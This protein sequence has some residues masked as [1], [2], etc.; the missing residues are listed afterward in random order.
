MTIEK[1]SELTG[2]SIKSL[3][4]LYRVSRFMGWLYWGFLAGFVV[5]MAGAYFCWQLDYWGV[6]LLLAGLASLA[7]ALTLF[8][9][10][11]AIAVPVPDPPT[12]FGSAAPATT[13]AL[14]TANLVGPQFGEGIRLGF[15]FKSGPDGNKTS[16]VMRYTGP[17]NL[18]LVAPPRSGKFRDELCA[19]MLEYGAASPGASLVVVD[20]K[21]E[22]CAVTRRQR[23]KLGRVF[24]LSPFH[25][26]LEKD[27]VHLGQPAR[28]S[29]MTALMGMS[30][31]VP[32]CDNL[33]ESIVRDDPRNTFFTASARELLS[34][35]ILHLLQS[36]DFPADKKT[37]AFV[38]H[39]ITTDPFMFARQAFATG[40]DYVKQRVASLA[41]PEAPLDK[42]ANSVL[43]T[44][45][46]ETAFIGNAPI[47]AS[48]SGS[49]FDFTELKKT[50]TTVYVV[51]PARY[52]GDVGGRWFRLI[53]A[54]ALNALMSGGRGL[55]VLVVIDE[56]SALGKMESIQRAMAYSSG[57]GFQVWPIMQSLEQFKIDYKGWKSFLGTA[58]VQQFYRPNEME[59][60]TYISELTGKKT[61]SVP[62]S[63]TSTN[64]AADGRSTTSASNSISLQQ[65]PLYRPDQIMMIGREFFIMRDE[66]VDYIIRGFRAPYFDERYH[67]ELKGLYDPNPYAPGNTA[68]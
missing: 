44:A 33:A 30:D 6:Y 32:G 1:I 35:F 24:V 61:V 28:F 2:R 66:T 37:L 11:L 23:A 38:R 8:V 57:L 19:A 43:Y 42:T 5:G 39:M 58:A 40:S 41:A 55:R 54:S 52:L 18:I 13:E 46:T 59:T 45:R 36:P 47:S 21:G 64:T 68:G 14:T 10:L 22:I 12:I 3:E 53:T 7:V 29:P 56:F 25:E 34:G 65:Q 63:S 20:P 17:G 16:G 27:G 15:A 60:A 51:V 67:P 31:L 26:E 62:G 48:L 49:D 50:P 4:R 9:I